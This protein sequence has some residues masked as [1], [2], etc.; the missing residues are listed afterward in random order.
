MTHLSDVCRKFLPAVVLATSFFV[1]AASAADYSQ[2][3]QPGWERMC[4]R[5]DQPIN[6]CSSRP[7]RQQL[8][9]TNELAML[10]SQVNSDVNARYRFRNDSGGDYWTV[11]TNGTADCEDYVMAKML[12][13]HNSGVDL[14]ATVMLIQ[15]LRNGAW[16]VTLGVRTDNGTV[17]LDSL[18]RN[19]S[20]VAGNGRAKFYLEMHNTSSWRVA[21]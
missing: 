9:Y 19:T 1:G 6:F 21:G 2:I 10:L 5:G 7:G 4:Q 16:H 3:R 12:Q 15:Q 11:P 13:L 8:S 18:Q 14:S 17:I 20:I